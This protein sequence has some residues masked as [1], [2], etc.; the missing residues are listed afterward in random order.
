MAPRAPLVNEPAALGKL[1]DQW[2]EE[3]EAAR[4]ARLSGVPR[5]P[6]TG[7]PAPDRELGEHRTPGLH[8]VH[9]EPGI[10]KMAHALRAA[11]T[12]GMPAVLVIGAVATAESAA[13]TTSTKET[14]RMT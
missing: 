5:C 14:R 12:C 7:F 9:G 10:G 1:A 2:A 4:A 8:F 6:A 11:A 13:A 3:A